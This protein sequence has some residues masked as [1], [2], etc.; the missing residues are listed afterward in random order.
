MPD[1]SIIETLRPRRAVVFLERDD[2]TCGVGMWEYD[3]GH[4]FLI[5][6]ANSSVEWK[7]AIKLK[8]GGWN[9]TINYYEDDP[10]YR[11]SQFVAHGWCGCSHHLDHG[12]MHGQA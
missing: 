10:G 12:E 6:V 1:K 11:L 9:Y 5:P 2:A 7:H 8:E 3:D 4:V